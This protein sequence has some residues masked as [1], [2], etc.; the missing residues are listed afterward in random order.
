MVGRSVVAMAAGALLSIGCLASNNGGSGADGGIPD[1]GAFTVR[2]LNRLEYNNTVRDLIGDSSQPANAFPPD[3]VATTFD[4]NS[5]VLTIPSVLVEDYANAAEALMT[6]ALATGSPQRATL[7]T[8]DGISS[9]PTTCAGQIL[10][11]FAKRAWRRPV[12]DAEIANLVAIATAAQKGGDSFENGIALALQ[13]VLVDPNFVFRVEI[14]PDPNAATPR[15][16]NDYELATRLSYF[17]YASMPDDALFAA[18]DAGTLHD[19]AQLDAQVTRMLADAKAAGFSDSFAAQ[20]LFTRELAGAM[21]SPTVYPAF[22]DGLRAAMAQETRLFFGD[23]LSGDASFLDMLDAD[24]TF[25]NDRL[26]KHYG[27]TGVTGPNFQ[28]VPLSGSPR[29][30]GLLSQA[31]ILTVTSTPNRPSIPKRGKF[32]LAELLCAPPPD[33]PPGVPTLPDQPTPGLTERQTLE[34]VTS[35]SPVCNSCHSQLNP[36]GGGLDHFDAIGA[37][38]TMSNNL[39]VDATGKLPDGTSFDGNLALGRLLKANPAVPRC[40][41]QKMMSYALGRELAAADGA[42]IDAIVGSVGKQGNKL[43]DLALAI[44]HDPHFTARRGGP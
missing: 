11:P 38:R 32:V 13:A 27:L 3:N 5:D 18:A 31:S 15:A 16:L 8:C 33:P 35:S 24:F 25:A 14:D 4:N 30:G 34:A 39:P 43:R 19:P 21:P 20:W 6:A 1:P 9:D 42:S 29:G 36:L 41:A 12:S 10:R 7:I 2:R 17:I 23:F 28:K 44:V 22:D 40:V 37:Y 26:A